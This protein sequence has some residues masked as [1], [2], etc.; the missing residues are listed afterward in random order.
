[1]GAR[2]AAGVSH[3]SPRAPNVSQPSETPPI[4]NEKAPRERDKERNWGR[5]REKKAR[6]VG[7]SV[8]GGSGAGVPGRECKVEE[9]KKK[10]QKIKAF[11]K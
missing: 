8:G 2:K 6:N 10:K 7:R 4:F 5:E 1:M 9:M 11:E 3:D